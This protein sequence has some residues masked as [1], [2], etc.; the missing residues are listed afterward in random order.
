MDGF[1]LQVQTQAMVEAEAETSDVLEMQD[2]KNFDSC[3]RSFQ[4]EARRRW[5][6]N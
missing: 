4:L 3:R 1:I 5:G 6:E 2:G